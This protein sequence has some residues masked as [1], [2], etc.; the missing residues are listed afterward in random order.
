[1]QR[2]DQ[3]TCTGSEPWELLIEDVRRLPMSEHQL[4][5]DYSPVGLENNITNNKFN[6]KLLRSRVE[7]LRETESGD[8]VYGMYHKS[9]QT[10]PLGMRFSELDSGW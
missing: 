8:C 10:G 7:S 1:M 4:S 9:P 2:L 5:S 6:H 3:F